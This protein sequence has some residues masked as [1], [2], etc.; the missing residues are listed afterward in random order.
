MPGNLFYP[1]KSII[2]AYIIVKPISVA[3][4]LPDHRFTHRQ[5][6]CCRVCSTI[7]TP[8]KQS[9]RFQA[10]KIVDVAEITVN[11]HLP[12]VRQLNKN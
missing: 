6:W 3:G 12:N 5:D 10:K 9:A 7:L 4:V 2:Q 11:K 8:A 1:P